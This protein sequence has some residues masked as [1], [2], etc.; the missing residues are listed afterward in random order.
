MMELVPSTLA[1]PCVDDDKHV[2][3]RWKG[4]DCSRMA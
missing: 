4:N 2:R 3:D 1:G